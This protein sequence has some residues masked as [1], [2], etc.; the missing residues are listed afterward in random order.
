MKNNHAKQVGLWMD[1]SKA[2][3]IAYANGEAILVE[4]IDSPVESIK[5]IEGE[6]KDTT[7]FTSSAEHSSNNEYKKHNIAQKE[8]NEYFRILENKLATY[9]D[10][11]IFGPGVAKEQ[12]RNRLRENK[13]FS[14][15]WLSIQSSDKLTENQLLAYVRDFYKESNP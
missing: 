11:L 15:K 13:G 5:R 4:N 6:V 8:L 2:H 14:E 12:F 3:V 1:H 7:R 9:D 10:I